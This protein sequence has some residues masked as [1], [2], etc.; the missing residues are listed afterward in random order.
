MD[1]KNFTKKQLIAKVK[2][3]LT[4]K[5]DILKSVPSSDRE[6]VRHPNSIENT[7]NALFE[8]SPD[9]LFTIK[10]DGEVIWVNLTGAKTL[11]Y[12]RNE[13]IG[14]PVWNVVHEDDLSLIKSKVSD[15]I[16]EK[17]VHAELY[18]YKV[19]KDGALLYVHERTQL[20]FNDDG[21][22]KEI[23]IICRDITQRKLA[24]DALKFEEQKFKSITNNLNVGIYRSTAD[25]KGTF[26]DFNPAFMKMFGFS[27][28]KELME[29]NVSSIYVVPVD[30]KRF[31]KT[32][33]EKG[34]VKNV[35]VLLQKKNGSR[36]IAS[37][38][39]IVT[40]DQKGH[41]KYY[42]G[43]IE[44][45]SVR[46]A[47]ETELI[48]SEYKYRTLIESFSDIIF[49][50]DYNSRMLFANPAL[51]KQTGFGVKDFKIIQKENSNIHPDDADFHEKFI[52]RFIKSKR[53][54]SDIIE[55][56]IIDKKGKTHWY[57]SVISKIE[58][59]HKPA[60]QFIVRDITK[61]KEALDQLLKSEEQYRTLFNFSPDGILLENMEGTIID[62]NPAMCKLTGYKRDELVGKK[63]HM[64]AHPGSLDQVD[65]NLFMLK[66]GKHLKHVEKSLRRD[67][68]PVLIELNERKFVLPDGGIG[69]ICIADDITKKAKAEENLKNSEESYRGLFNSSSDAIYIQDKDGYFVDVNEGAV[70]MYGYPR[71]FFIGKTPEFLS[72]PGMNDLKKTARLIRKA[73][74]G[75][76]QLFEFWGIDKKGRVFPKEVRLNKGHYFG[77]DVVIVFAQDIT[78]RKIAE[79]I[80]I[81]SEKKYRKI[82]NAFPDIYF[83][84]DLS[85]IIE[86]ISP[87]VKRIA[88]YRPEEIIGKYSRDFYYDSADWDKIGDLLDANGKLEDFD[89]RIKNKANKI[90]NCSLTAFFIFDE[91]NE[92]I[93]VEGA[94]RDISD[95]KRAEFNL[96]ENQRR[97]ATLMSNLPGMAYRCLNDETWTMEFVSEG[98]FDLTG[99]KST[100]LLGNSKIS[101]ND[102]IHPDDRTIVR[103][104]VQKGLEKSEPFRMIY[105]IVTKKGKLKWVWEQG[106]GIYSDEGNLIAL[107]G[108]I[109]NITEQKLAE[110][111][112]R[113]F[114][115]SVEQ[116]PTIVVIAD[117]NGNIEYVNPRFTKVTGY[118]AKEVLHKN[119]SIL[120]S[121][122]TPLS[123]YENLWQNITSGKEWS[124]EFI[125]KKKNGD[126]YWESANIFPLKDEKGKIT[127]F[128]AM[129]EDITYRKLMEQD[130]VSAK[131]KAEES[132]KLKS[133]FL[134]NMSHEIRTPMNAIIGFSQLLAEAD[135]SPDEQNQYISLIQKS[136]SDLLGLIDDIIDISKIE[137]GQL[138]IYKSDYFVDSILS[139][140][141]ES[142]I[143]YLKTTQS[144][145]NIS[146]RYN[147]SEKL[148]NIV[149]HTD[150]DKLKQVIRN[151]INNA[152][153][154]T[155]AGLIEFGAELKTDG[156]NTLLQ[157]YVRDTGIG[158]PN[159]KLDIIFESFRQLD[160]PNK[161]I[162]GGTGLGLAITRKIV[163]ILGGKIWVKSIPG[164]GSTFYFNLHCNPL[165]V[166]GKLNTSEPVATVLKSYNWENK[167]ILI[168]EDDEQSFLFYQSV[169]RKTKMRVSKATDGKEAL[170][171]SKKIKF[172]LI[173][174]DIRM[175]VMDG[176]LTTQKILALDPSAKIIAQTAYA[177][178]GERQRSLDAGCIDYITKPIPIQEFLKVIEK[179]I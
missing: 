33:A 152:I 79:R 107:E 104:S 56:R 110:E 135:T 78:E 74:Q 48:N 26:L 57:S 105:R 54:H 161:R 64:L 144:N 36:F 149:L 125:N 17:K 11:G 10:P 65:K 75:E 28:R 61:Q 108:F 16:N 19:R 96:K 99:Y 9:M 171:I 106:I 176:Y 170:A 177:M 73:F 82:F 80:L 58:F 49:I 150:I 31:L 147:R 55:N 15:I 98:C 157:F 138:K 88:G 165:Q 50:T 25:E 39:T 113:K 155:D 83:R 76:S 159:D 139:E 103:T 53:L 142:Y 23:R 162:Y 166:T 94:I 168:V 117:L 131:E 27:S 120:K 109:A 127:H 85:G 146:F 123:V 43:I 44:D 130:L 67:G 97:L 70:K 179:Y 47:T 6:I 12:K 89:T 112:M 30:R 115:R 22:V 71:Q 134:A 45:I 41:S 95:R 158:I 34:S 37:V 132:A 124:G 81:E 52:N 160:V 133:A 2:E 111:E 77:K 86:E 118:Q 163:E 154:F 46:R 13:L 4:E 1:F 29:T 7:F 84:T 122:K 68:T 51:K 20:V 173:L 21:E 141:Y 35:E 175:P 8:S 63:V 156:R 169:L 18:F 100:D 143:K 167:H 136:G 87:S 59:D 119:T 69:V 151:L 164:E 5:E 172:D 129:K 66:Q 101:Y 42:D 174:M 62:A 3:L 153:K 121:G 128:I 24:E 72:A 93:G 91:K 114:S 40:K 14:K 148:E 137:A 178:A 60:L 32:I 116:S 145:K 38:S 126:L 140:V 90:L 92:P 102:L